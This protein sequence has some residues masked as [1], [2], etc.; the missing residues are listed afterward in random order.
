MQ[1]TLF[2]L[3][4]GAV[5][6]LLLYLSLRSVHLGSI[7]A[8]L[9]S[10]KPAWLLGAAALMLVQ[11]GLGAARWREIVNAGATRLAFARALQFNFIGTFFSQVLPS[12][13]G[14]DAARIWLLARRGGGWAAATYSV[15][16]DRVIGVTMLALIVIACLPWTMDIVHDPIARG[17]LLLIGFGVLA[18]AGLFLALG[19]VPA[20]LAARVALLRHLAA[21][22]RM[23]WVLCRTRRSALVLAGTSL[24]IHLSTVAMVWCCAQSVAAP[25]GF[26]QVLFLLP[27]VLLIATVP[28]SIA[29]WGVRESSM[30]V[31]FGYAGLAQ[32]DGL[33]LSI[34][35]GLVS[36]AVGAIGG[37]VWIASGF[38]RLS[39][40][41]ATETPPLA[42]EAHP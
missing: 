5:S 27:P 16:I 28:I 20:R 40:A 15:L 32:S 6:V 30:V 8:R 25:V 23:T 11:I 10:A 35:F 2:L 41:A 3:L 21:A 39:F 7:A 17:L 33:T 4:K 18:A 37:V 12:T 34:L 22:S 36:F 38:K 42:D 24:P 29:G 19:L 14:G 31:A 1:R 13:V 9:T 26:E